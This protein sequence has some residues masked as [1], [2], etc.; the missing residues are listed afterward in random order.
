MA[1]LAAVPQ[2][3]AVPKAVALYPLTFEHHASWWTCT[4]TLGCMTPL[5]RDR[6]LDRHG[7]GELIDV[8]A[9]VLK[10]VSAT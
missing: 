1:D 8:E 5:G 9:R 10:N 6:S 2:T 4:V 3:E 7:C